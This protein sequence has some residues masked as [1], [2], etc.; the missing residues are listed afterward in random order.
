MKRIGIIILLFCLA[1]YAVTAAESAAGRWEEQLSILQA[2][3]SGSED[4]TPEEAQEAVALLRSLFEEHPE[5][6]DTL[7]AE[8]GQ[9]AE[10]EA[11][12]PVAYILNIR[13]NRFH[14]PE[15]TGIRDMAE[16][17]RVDYYGSRDLLLATGFQP[18]RLCK[19]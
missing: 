1:L 12:V 19:P 10:G 13:S 4:I 18:C 7:R 5:V 15:C 17:N 9:T 8:P 14:K 6:L 3:L 16:K 2:Y 11:P